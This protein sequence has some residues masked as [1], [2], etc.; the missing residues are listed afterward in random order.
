MRAHGGAL[1]Q[2]FA[3]AL[4]ANAE[5]RAAILNVEMTR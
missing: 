4:A 3:E 5:G 2:A 1:G